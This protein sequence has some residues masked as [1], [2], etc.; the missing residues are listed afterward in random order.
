MFSNRNRNSD[1]TVGPKSMWSKSPS[2]CT[3]ECCDALK[4]SARTHSFSLSIYIYKYTYRYKLS[5]FSYILTNER[6]KRKNL[7]H[8]CKCVSGCQVHT[9]CVWVSSSLSSSSFLAY[10]KWIPRKK[11]MFVQF[12]CICVHN[13]EIWIFDDRQLVEIYLL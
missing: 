7:N 2:Q 8:I 6:E 9:Y 3:H 4:K 12:K 10:V 1:D 13:G 5:I 11:I